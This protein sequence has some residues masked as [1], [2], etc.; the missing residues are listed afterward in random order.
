MKK[1][2]SKAS[3]KVQKVMHEFKTGTLHSGSKKGPT[4]TSKKQA[5]AIAMSEAGM[6]KGKKKGK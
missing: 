1:K 5:I 6:K 2:P 3:K 4:V